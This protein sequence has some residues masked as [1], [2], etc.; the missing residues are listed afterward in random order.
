MPCACKCEAMKG[1]ELIALLEESAKAA[2]VNI[3]GF[4][5]S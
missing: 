1:D 4:F 5:E 2:V 3:K